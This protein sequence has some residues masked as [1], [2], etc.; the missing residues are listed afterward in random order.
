MQNDWVGRRAYPRIDVNLPVHF[1]LIDIK[2]R[3]RPKARYSAETIDISM[4][5]LGI[6]I[7]NQI[8]HMI[9]IAIKMMGD[10]KKYDLEIGIDLGRDEVRAVGE[11]KWSL[12][13]IPHLLK[14]GIFIKG[15]EHEEEW[16]WTSFIE[17]QYQEITHKPGPTLR[18]IESIQMASDHLNKASNR[19]FQQ[20]KT[21]EAKPGK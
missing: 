14:M 5:G 8:L 3:I 12:L 20:M 6:R 18:V 9:P 1:G 4:K 13:D 19:I 17:K 15:M 2:G 21:Y 10:N 11:V 16:K 7:D